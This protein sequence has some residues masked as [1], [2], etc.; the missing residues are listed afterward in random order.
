MITF[1]YQWLE[2]APFVL[3]GQRPI[4]LL[5]RA[6]AHAGSKPWAGAT[7]IGS[8]SEFWVP[9]SSPL[10]PDIEFSH[11][12]SGDLIHVPL[13]AYRTV[14]RLLPSILALGVQVGMAV[15]AE[16]RKHTADPAKHVIL[17]LGTECTDLSPAFECYRCYVGVA[18]QTK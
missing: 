17:V 6:K 8:L 16:M 18:V 14:H 15:I 13:F 7:Q 12:R 3:A 2:V 9:K 4:A 5:P 10:E 1:D 11:T